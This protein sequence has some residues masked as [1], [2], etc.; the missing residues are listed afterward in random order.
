MVFGIVLPTLLVMMI[1]IH[2]NLTGHLV[3]HGRSES[4]GK[5]TTHHMIKPQEQ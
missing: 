1:S 4:M 2:R 3:E 5:D